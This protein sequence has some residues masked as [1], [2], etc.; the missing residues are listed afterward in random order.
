[1]TS[2]ANKPEDTSANQSPESAFTNQSV[3]ELLS[4]YLDGEVSEQERALVENDPGLLSRLA[5]FQ[6][7]NRLVA[8]PFFEARREEIIS[9]ALAEYSQLFKA[10]V[11]ETDVHETGALRSAESV[12]SGKIPNLLE[13]DDGVLASKHGLRALTRAN[14]R[15]RV[16]MIGFGAIALLA[17]GFLALAIVL[18]VNEN[19]NGGETQAISEVTVSPE[20]DDF[21]SATTASAENADP[22]QVASDL[23]ATS[24]PTLPESQSLLTD[25]APAVEDIESSLPMA[26]QA[27]DPTSASPS[28][29]G[30][31]EDETEELSSDLP[32]QTFESQESSSPIPGPLAPTEAPPPAIETPPP[33]IE[34]PPP[35]IEAPPPAIEIQPFAVDEADQLPKFDT[36]MIDDE[37]NLQSGEPFSGAVLACEEPCCPDIDGAID[38]AAENLGESSQANNPAPDE[39]MQTDTTTTT[40]SEASTATSLA[41]EEG[42]SDEEEGAKPPADADACP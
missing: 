34:A 15:R 23:D 14:K 32:T 6:E 26:Q 35:A 13:D 22:S 4:A 8:A 25:A 41:G 17:S 36:P 42:L 12:T 28:A 5:Q 19:Q 38:D 16:S 11:H 18:F 29:A 24:P 20:T 10:G 27:D 39:K 31:T 9:T 2:D 33:A 21:S 30:E 7:I 40:T 37:A 1:M 3:D